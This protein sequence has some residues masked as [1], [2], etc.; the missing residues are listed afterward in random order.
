MIMI[1][2]KISITETPTTIINKIKPD[3]EPKKKKLFFNA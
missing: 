3:T 2:I 1:I